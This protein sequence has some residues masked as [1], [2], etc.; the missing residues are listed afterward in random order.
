MAES[1]NAPHS[2]AS[3]RLWWQDLGNEKTKRVIEMFRSRATNKAVGDYLGVVE[4][5]AR[6]IRVKLGKTH[7]EAI[8]ANATRP[9]LVE[10]AAREI[11]VHYNTLRRWIHV[12]RVKAT[13]RSGK[14]SGRGFLLIIRDEV[15]RLKTSIHHLPW[16]N[17][18]ERRFDA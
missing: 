5:H 15:E 12:G 8:F 6:Q 16:R 18:I 4:E 1:Q 2:E 11:G 17:K 13:L 3:V 9:L 7:G 14:E 10:E